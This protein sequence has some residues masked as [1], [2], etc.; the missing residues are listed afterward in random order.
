M[1][2]KD[3]EREVEKLDSK[4]KISYLKTELKN[5]EN[6]EIIKDIKSL[7][8]K[9]LK[10][11]PLSEFKINYDAF[12]EGL[13]PIYFWTLDFMRDSEPSGLNLKVSKIGEGLEASASSGYFSDIGSK[14]SIMQDRAMKILQTVNAVVKSIINLIYDLKEFEVRLKEYDKLTYDKQIDR[15][16]GRLSLKGVWMDQVDIKKGR[17]SINMMA[18]QLQF[19][20]LRDAF[21]AAESLDWAN[22]KELDLNDRVRRILVK[23]LEE[24]FTWEEVSEKELRK[25]FEI[26]RSYLKTQRDTL[27]LYTKWLAPYLKAAQKLGMKEFNMP[28]IVAGFNNMQMELSLFG[29]K[30]MDPSDVHESFKK[31]KFDKKYF[32][33]LEIDFN[34]RSVPQQARTQSGTHYVHTGKTEII[35]KSYSFDDEELKLVEEQ[36]LYEDL[37]LIEQ[38][39]NVSLKALEEDI[40]YFLNPPAKCPEC[41]IELKKNICPKCGYGKKK[42]PMIN[43]FKDVIDGF[44]SIIKPMKDMTDYILPKKTKDSFAMKEIKKASETKARGL[45]YTAY[46]VYKK[47]HGMITW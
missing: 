18:Q 42:E 13:E 44:K 29:K 21:M 6:K 32:A 34:F 20:T 28:D 12:G 36:E 40:E 24:Y 46:D 2:I 27:M 1:N 38:L 8:L 41:G 7:L 22:K 23:K 10:K 16:A 9:E 25:R 17:G 19:V 3:I 14:A 11:T 30:E 37:G 15:E 45:C 39:T 26:E 4:G 47:A 5:E 35:F 31:F 43:P 33:C